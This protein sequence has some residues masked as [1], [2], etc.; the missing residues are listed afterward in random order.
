MIR[1]KELQ[2]RRR[3][4][5]P[6][7]RPPAQGQQGAPAQA[8]GEPLPR[9]I[10]ASSKGPF[11]P[12]AYLEPPALLHPF[13]VDDGGSGAEDDLWLSGGR[14]GTS[15]DTTA[16][17]ADGARGVQSPRGARARRDA[18]RG[19]AGGYVDRLLAGYDEYD[20][21]YGGTNTNTSDE[22]LPYPYPYGAA[23]FEVG[24]YDDATRAAPESLREQ[25]AEG[26]PAVDEEAAAEVG[27]VAEDASPG[28]R[29]GRR[30]KVIAVEGD[31]PGVGA[32]V[33]VEQPQEAVKRGR[34]RRL[35]SQPAAARVAAILDEG[36][37]AGERPA[38]APGGEADGAVE[39]G[40]HA[41]QAASGTAALAVVAAVGRAARSR[42]GGR[43]EME[44]G[45]AGLE[46]RARERKPGGRGSK[47]AAPRA[48][49]SHGS[50]DT[51]LQASPGATGPSGAQAAEARRRRME[52][53]KVGRR[54]RACWAGGSRVALAVV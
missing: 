32:A 13:D 51:G 53:L 36:V 38:V 50:L 46:Q 33:Q 27:H 26:L 20:S 40:E 44:D 41:V 31:D 21:M 12:P 52:E 7:P 16:P 29:R 30:R 18:S 35:P 22:W 47:A 37:P 15:P 48:L 11:A 2:L 5:Q 3:A 10:S 25:Q 42:M 14:G 9:G 8:P 19:L 17:A 54:A 6:S 1:K 43:P 34:R 45:A 28:R 23:W 4:A 24:G 39:A 49:G